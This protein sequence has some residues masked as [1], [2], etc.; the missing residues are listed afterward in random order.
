MKLK[1]E[2]AHSSMKSQPRRVE[3]RDAKA[4]RR[5]P[6]PLRLLLWL[7]RDRCC[8]CR[9]PARRSCCNSPKVAPV[10]AGVPACPGYTKAG[11]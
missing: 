6:L 4:M 7:P 11:E 1:S 3:R 9:L 8:A 2:D 10:L 5:L